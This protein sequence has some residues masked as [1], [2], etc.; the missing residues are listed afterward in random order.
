MKYV[1]AAVVL[2]CV[3]SGVFPDNGSSTGSRGMSERDIQLIYERCWYLLSQIHVDVAGLDEA[4]ELYHEVLEAAPRDRDIYWKLSEMIFKKAETVESE[5]ESRE[6]YET[7]LDFAKK[8]RKNFPDSLEA[9]FWVGC[10]SARVSEAIGNI[11]A[12]PI[13]NEAISE[14]EFTIETSPG[15]RFAATAGAILAA[16]YT[17]SP[18]PLRNLRKAET[19][20]L[21]AVEKDPAL[22]L[23]RVKLAQV[24][25]ERKQ[26]KKARDEATLCLSLRT[27]TY[28]WDAELYDW[29]EARLLLQEI[30]NER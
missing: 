27:P 14:L 29:P 25:K 19:Y 2:S 10:C 17:E 13:V 28:I 18:W 6:L 3:L 21:M 11:L 15:H 8:A 5:R 9:H 1:V 12:L 26:F 22:T 23:A 20:G 30:E 16:I 7:A 4:I 24:Y